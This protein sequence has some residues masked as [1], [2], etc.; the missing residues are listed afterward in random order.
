MAI[1]RVTLSVPRSIAARLRKAAGTQPVSAWVTT[2]IEE[3]LD[4]TELEAQFQ[5]FCKQHAPT[6]VEAAKAEAILLRLR[7]Q[8]RAG[9][10]SA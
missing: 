7:R 6:K 10:R 5:T 1:E 3:H 8:R 2:L 9:K 4:Q